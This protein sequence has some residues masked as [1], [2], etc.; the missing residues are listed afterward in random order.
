[1]SV[2]A[3]KM[4]IPEGD[5]SICIGNEI[6]LHASFS[7]GSFVYFYSAN[8]KAYFLDTVARSWT[9]AKAAAASNGM[10]LWVINQ[11]GEN[12]SVQSKITTKNQNSFFW[13]GLYQDPTVEQ[14]GGSF[15]DGWKW[16]DGTP[17]NPA[18]TYWASNINE[19]NNQFQTSTPANFGSMGFNGA[20]SVWSDM[21]DS[22][23]A[24]YF[25]YA[26][27][28]MPIASAPTFVWKSQVGVSAPIT[29]NTSLPVITV[30]PSVTTSYSVS[31]NMGTGVVQSSTITVTVN[32]PL[33]SALFSI[34]AD[35]ISCLVQNNFNFILDQSGIADPATTSYLWDF[36]DGNKS[37]QGSNLS[38]QYSAPG[39]YAVSLTV[40]DKNGCPS[41]FTLPTP[42][43]VRNAPLPT[44]VSAPQKNIC[45]GETTTISVPNPQAGVAYTWTDITG[46]ILGLGTTIVAS[47]TG[48]YI[49]EAMLIS[50]GCK[51]TVNTEILVNPLPVTPS[52]TAAAAV[53]CQS[54][55][56][57]LGTVPLVEPPLGYTWFSGVTPDSLGNTILGNYFAKSPS[58]MGITPMT[59]DFYVRTTD[60]NKCNSLLSSP[61]SITF[62]PSP[63][64][65]ISSSGMPTSF[66]IGNS[67]DLAI[68]N[69]QGALN[70]FWSKDNIV[71]PLLN[72]TNSNT[73]DSTGTYR[74]RAVNSPYN[75]TTTSN[76]INVV[77]NNYP[78]IPTIIADANA[79]EITPTGFKICPGTNSKLSTSPLP[80]ASYQWFINDTIIPSAQS[81]SVTI[82]RAGA[83]TVETS[84][85]G[86]PSGST[87]TMVGLLPRAQ[88]IFIPP[89]VKTICNGYTSPLIASNA[90]SYQW[91]LNYKPIDSATSS[92]F[93]AASSGVYQVEFFT[94]KG[95]KSMSDSLAILSVLKKPTPAFTYDL[96]CVNVPSIFTNQSISTNSGPVTYLWEFQ[97][98]ETKDSVDVMHV[99]P[100][101]GLYKVILNVIPTI[102]PQLVDSISATIV[103][104][105]PLNGV[106]Y[107]PVE[108]RVGKPISLIAR[109]FGVAFEWVPSTGLDNPNIRIPLLIPTTEQLYTVKILNRAGCLNVD[110]VLVR[111]FDEQDIFIAGGFTP[112]ND[113]KND[114][115]YPFLVGINSFNY[116]KIFNRWGNLVFQTTSVD[117]ALGWDGKYK[118][119]DQPADTYTW[120]VEGEGENGKVFRKSGSLILIR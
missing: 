98:G 57:L 20:Q 12:A 8:G 118:G 109:S 43:V 120:I 54:D 95:C 42:L 27:A 9:G 78:P 40:R 47:T 108:A 36:K 72:N 4:V 93:N 56:L 3:Q 59:I 52:I 35:S 100:T 99:F 21:P 94:D 81:Q 110:S 33:S 76:P 107:P 114:K 102:C 117:P 19:P 53:V 69:P 28:E 18:L 83:Y 101:T 79:P 112:N 22:P 11:V 23:P 51:D 49:L 115:I 58:N 113:G 39:S 38:H 31:L 37:Y 62:N 75:C 97:N 67:V 88:G 89:V 13:I 7:I 34:A 2:Q 92:S 90:F 82:N 24:P 105:S 104:E 65:Q 68:T 84:V 25:G 14:A 119:R 30:Q 91:Y 48:K 77:V 86:C 1:M 17:L 50:S 87:K 26:I 80:G 74:V 71:D 96:F 116:L 41:T 66:C 6:T 73:F 15:S 46:N 55:S 70:Y 64:V 16:V 29:T 111:I 85:N 5:T 63:K 60:K 103:V 10:Q 61:Y 32:Q 106:L 45:Q 44:I